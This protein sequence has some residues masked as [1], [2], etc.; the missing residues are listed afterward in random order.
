MAFPIMTSPTSGHIQLHRD[1]EAGT[2]RGSQ[3]ASNTPYIVSDGSSL[4]KAKIAAAA[5]SPLWFQLYPIKDMDAMKAWA[6]NVQTLGG[7][8]VVMTVDQQAAFYERD[9]HE[10]HLISARPTRPVVPPGGSGNATSG[11]RAYRVPERRLWYN[12]KYAEQVK[13]ML[14]SPCSR[15][16]FSPRDAKPASNTASMESMS[17]TTARPVTTSHHSEVLPEIVDA[18]QGRVRCCSIAASAPARHIKPS[19][20]AQGSVH[21]PRSPLGAGRYG[22]PGVRGFTKF[23]KAG[24]D[25]DGADR[26][27]TL[28]SID[29]TLVKLTPIDAS[30]R[31]REVG[32]NAFVRMGNV[33]W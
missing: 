26:Q 32:G 17:P 12:W 25:G 16:A 29:R 7:K 14:K 31:K 9:F 24:G 11:P 21:R 19:R 5:T 23:C 15:R 30:A 28:A 8:A 1:A 6:E 13:A 2:Y 20:W 3:G 27:A 10:Q 4:P 18:V 22:A 33:R